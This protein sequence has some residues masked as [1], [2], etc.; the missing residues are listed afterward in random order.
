MLHCIAC[1]LVLYDNPAPTSSAIV[2][3]DGKVML[4]RRAK[5]PALGMWDLPGGF[6]EPG[7]HPERTLHRELLEETGLRVRVTGLLGFF[8]DTYGDGGTA[9]LN[10]FY[11]AE[12]EGG[13]EAPADDVSEI[14]WF[15]LDRLPAASQ[16]AF[17]NGAEALQAFL[18]A[19]G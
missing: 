15:P 4:T 1:G 6:V 19:A 3:R 9:T 13:S 5:E 2:T 7:E 8:C 17:R 16:I 11:T 14:G 12:A 10:I 18:R